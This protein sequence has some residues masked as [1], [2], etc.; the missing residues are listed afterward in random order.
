MLKVGEFMSK[1]ICIAI[2]GP[3]AAGKSTI[4]KKLAEKLRYIYIDTGAMYRATTYAALQKNV[5]LSDESAVY[6]VLLHS[7]LDLKHIEGTQ[8]I[9]LDGV[10]ISTEIRSP[11]VTKNVSEVAGYL[12]VRKNLVMRQ[13]R[14]G[15][16]GGVVMDGRDIATAVLPFAEVKIFMVASVMERAK[17]RHL[18]NL[19]K[20]FP[21]NL[22][23][24][25]EEI[26]KRDELDSTRTHSPLKQSPD[27]VRVDTT[28]KTQD[29]VLQEIYQLVISRK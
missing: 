23:E 24:I 11:E 16:N 3:A 27:S 25:A 9:F 29:E 22:G 12:S 17:R 15:E 14:L 1:K 7:E 8:R 21:S 18:E 10:D 4:A 5:N 28:G 13:Q 6:E 20:G 26:K 19:E 2:D